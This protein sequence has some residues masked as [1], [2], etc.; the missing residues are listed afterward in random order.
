MSTRKL[1]AWMQREGR[2]HMDLATVLEISESMAYSLINGNRTPSPEL[3]AKLEAATGISLRKPDEHARAAR[4][5][6]RRA[7]RFWGVSTDPD[8]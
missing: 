5:A 3:D 1:K 8:S 4:R 6:K 7:A 2:S